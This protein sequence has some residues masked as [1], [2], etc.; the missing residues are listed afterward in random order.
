MD[1]LTALRKERERLSNHLNWL[2]VRSTGSDRIEE[3]I[4]MIDAEI[5]RIEF[6][7]SSGRSSAS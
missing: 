3:R 6:E 2:G 7:A 5:E 1:R 4:R